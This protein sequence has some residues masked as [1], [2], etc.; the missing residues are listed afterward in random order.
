[1]EFIVLD[2]SVPANGIMIK[3]EGIDLSRFNKN[4]IML[5]QHQ[6]E[7]GIIGRWENLRNENGVFKAEAIFNETTELGKQVS[8][9]V[10]NGFLR[11]ASVGL[12]EVIWSNDLNGIKTVEKCVL[13]EISIVDLPACENAVKLKKNSNKQIFLTQPLSNEKDAF[14]KELAKL[15]DLPEDLPITKYLEAI[16]D[17][18]NNG[19]EQI[20]NALK[21]DYISKTEAKF[22]KTLRYDERIKFLAEYKEESIRRINSLIDNNR[23]KFISCDIPI[24]KDIGI[25]MGYKTLSKLLNIWPEPLRPSNLIEDAKRI[26]NK[27]ANLTLKDYRRNP[28][29]LNNNPNLE[30]FVMAQNGEDIANKDLE[31]YRKNDPDYLRNNPKIYEDLINKEL[32]SNKQL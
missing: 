4:P 23:G 21:M 1:M 27:L 5:Y 15:L 31:W 12:D 8:Y 18:L 19:V 29:L 3:P 13:T 20:E 6:R 2:C 24:F 11:G 32:N 17:I 30:A 7:N 22:L 10:R 9:D 14:F 28:E 16:K 26:N 25:K